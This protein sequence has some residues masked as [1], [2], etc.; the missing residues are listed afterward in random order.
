MSEIKLEFVVYEVITSI[1]YYVIP[2]VWIQIQ[3]VETIEIDWKFSES[4]IFHKWKRVLRT[5]RGVDDGE[6]KANGLNILWSF[7]IHISVHEGWQRRSNIS[8]IL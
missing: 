7:S 1:V 8:D 4:K 2:L 5:E 3:I 6:I